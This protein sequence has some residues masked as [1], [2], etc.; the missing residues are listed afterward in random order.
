MILSEPE[1]HQYVATHMKL[2]FYVG[3]EQQLISPAMTLEA[4]IKLPFQRK[5]QCR[6]ALYKN[7]HMLDSYI[8]ENAE[9]LQTDEIEILKGFKKNIQSDF[10]ILKCLTKNAIFINTKTNAIY[11]VKALSDRFDEFFRRFPAYCST[12]IIPFK[13]KIIYDGFISTHGNICLGPG[14]SANM[15][16]MYLQTKK[17]KGI[18]TTL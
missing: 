2:L 6:E 1:Y 5:Y 4:F 9:Q 16:E 11:A 17:Q 18:I 8:N 10:V 14:I 7:I 13:D 15:N 3:I 12:A